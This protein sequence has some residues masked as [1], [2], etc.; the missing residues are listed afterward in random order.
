MEM[1]DSLEKFD[2]ARALSRDP[3][4]AREA[5]ALY[6]EVAAEGIPEAQANLAAMLEAGD[7]GVPQDLQRAAELYA[8]AADAGVSAAAYNLGR[9]YDF[10]KG[11]PQNAR[12]AVELYKRAAEKG[13]ADAMVNLAA[14]VSRGEVG[15]PN[16]GRAI[17]WYSRAAHLGHPLGMRAMALAHL[18]G[19]AGS[20]VDPTIAVEWLEKAA[21][22]GDGYSWFK[23][24]QL[25]WRGLGMPRA[26]LQGLRYG[27]RAAKT[28][29]GWREIVN[30]LSPS[31]VRLLRRLHLTE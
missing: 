11:L 9:L 16:A 31:M 26:R 21:E 3:R 12:K 5:A 18:S 20:V 15:W 19:E 7:R 17:E 8:A 30:T 4:R 23:L 27:I 29:D 25:A 1:G 22:R 13:N 2:R 14:I 28:Q 24:G 6:E 10:G